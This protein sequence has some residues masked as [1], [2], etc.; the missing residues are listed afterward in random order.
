MDE[1]SLHN[2]VLQRID[3]AT[4]NQLEGIVTRYP[5]AEFLREATLEMLRT[6]PLHTLP[7][8]DF[9]AAPMKDLGD[10][11]GTVALPADFIRLASFRM[12]GWLRPVSTAMTTD[13]PA[14]SRQLNP[15]TRGGMAKP[16]AAIFRDSEG[17]KLRWFSLPPHMPRQIDEAFCIVKVKPADMPGML[18]D[19]LCWLAASLVLAVTNEQNAAAAARQ[20]YELSLSQL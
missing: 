12:H 15:V 11:T 5:V 19:P 4:S 7:K 1:T 17:L 16:A 13:D 18:T 2:G 14:Y 8:N 10:G 9:T 3:E 20:R 6:A